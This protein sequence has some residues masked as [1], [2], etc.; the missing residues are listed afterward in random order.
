M[1][2]T[3]IIGI[4]FEFSRKYLDHLARLFENISVE[5]YTW[6]VSC[7]ENFLSCD[8][9]KIQQFLPNGVYSGAEFNSIIHS[10]SNYYIH[11]IYILAV[12]I[13]SEIDT[14]SINSYEDYVNS[15]VEIALLSADS[16]VDLYAKD[17]GTLKSIFSSCQ[18]Y[19]ALGTITP[20]YITPQNDDRETFFV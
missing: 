2:E 19:Y 13:G 11:L 1:F 9:G 14:C 20:Q 7:S 8:D 18:K 6:Y 10:T 4:R 15:P 3:D 12:P 17:L 5:K 16:Y